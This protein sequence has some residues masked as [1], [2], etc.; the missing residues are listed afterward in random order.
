[1]KEIIQSLFWGLAGLHLFAQDSQYLRVLPD[2]A[3]LKDGRLASVD[4]RRLLSEAAE[5]R[6]FLDSG[7]GDPVLLPSRI[8]S[9]IMLHP[10]Y[11]ISLLEFGQLV[12]AGQI[13]K[14]EIKFGQFS[15]EMQHSPLGASVWMAIRERSDQLGPGK[16]APDFTAET[17]DGR[18]LRLS[19]L[20]GKYV[21][22]DF[23][24]SWCGPCRMENPNVAAN[25]RRYKNRDFVVLSFSLD[26]S[27][28]AW[29]QAIGA[30]GMDWLHAGDLKGWHSGIV[31]LYMVASV[32]KS[33]LIDPGGKIIAVDLRGDE[34][35]KILEQTIK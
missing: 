13:T 28:T 29:K 3:L 14:A 5:Y 32:P 18:Q 25:Y 22:L 4:R 20:R 21:L 12:E 2:S 10:D 9:F 17:P 6:N 31:Q 1:M 26:E 33:Y 34:L 27:R 23:W 16:T 8:K 30:D 11:W 35:G 24:A 15:P 19:D 7:A